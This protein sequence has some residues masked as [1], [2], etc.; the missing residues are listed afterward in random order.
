MFFKIFVKIYQRLIINKDNKTVSI[1]EFDIEKNRYIK[2]ILNLNLSN[3]NINLK[4]RIKM[5]NINQKTKITIRIMK[6][7]MIMIFGKKEKTN[8]V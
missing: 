5:K 2:D 3:N 8:W 6:P 7:I 4:K 1:E